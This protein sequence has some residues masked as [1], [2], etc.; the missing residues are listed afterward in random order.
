MPI[1]SLSSIPPR[2]GDLAPTLESLLAQDAD[3]DEVRLCLPKR[4]RRFP[5]YRGELPDLP[6]GVRCVVVEEDLGPGT[7][8]L[9]TVRDAT[10]ADEQVL[11]C[12]DDHVYPQNW[13]STLL[14][15]SVERPEACVAGFGCHLDRYS[16]RPDRKQPPG[17]ATFRSKTWDI[18][19][20][21]KRIGQQLREGR[22]RTMA[23]K[24]LRQ[25]VARPG[26][27]DILYGYAGAC[28]RP[29]FFDDA[30]YDIPDDIWMVDD[31]WLSGHFARKDIPIWLHGRT[32]LP[33]QAGNVHRSPLNASIFDG[34]KR[35]QLDRKAISYFQ[36]TYGI[37]R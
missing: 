8:V 15:E 6:K 28:V 2:F 12:D 4:F 36:Q 21:L 24:P 9:P 37:W 14:S 27:T 19:Y 5:E 17:Y 3:I 7:K 26:R 13:A 10:N 34:A 1:I 18:S 35:S 20:R 23:P 29:R 11:F 25:P 22:F 32:P 33:Q 16:P 30:F 31:V